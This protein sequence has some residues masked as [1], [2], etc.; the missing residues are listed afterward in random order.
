MIIRNSGVLARFSSED[1]DG[2]QQRY[3]QQD[4]TVVPRTGLTDKDWKK[5]SQVLEDWA[6]RWR[7]LPPRWA[8]RSPH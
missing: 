3:E 5:I 7:L 2:L 1:L 4:R 8:V 6:K